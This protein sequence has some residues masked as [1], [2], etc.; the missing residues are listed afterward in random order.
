MGGSLFDFLSLTDSTRRNE[1]RYGLS[2]RDVAREY[3]VRVGLT[4]AM[5]VVGGNGRVVVPRDPPY[6]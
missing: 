6:P 1:C 5:L 2:Q 4:A 3:R